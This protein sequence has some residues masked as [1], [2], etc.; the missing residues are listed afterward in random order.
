MND[1]SS[2]KRE[3]GLCRMKGCCNKANHGIAAKD[4]RGEQTG[5]H[6]RVRGMPFAAYKIPAFGAAAHDKAGLSGAICRKMRFPLI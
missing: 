2:I 6:I 4:E 1:V 3:F 5:S